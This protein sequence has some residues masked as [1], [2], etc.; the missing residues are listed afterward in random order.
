[1]NQDDPKQALRRDE[2]HLWLT[3]YDEIDDELQ[4]SYRRMVV[5]AAEIAQEQRF[6]F[7]NDRHRYLVTR[8]LV[9]TVL[10]RYASIAP[11]EWVFS[12]NKYGRPEVDNPEARSAGIVFNVS[13][14]RGL[15]ALG[16]TKSCALGLDVENV[17]STPVLLDLADRYF[18]PEELSALAALPR[19][20]QQDR[21]FEY[22][23]FKESYIKARGMGL[24]IPLDKFSFRY[25]HAHGV[26]IVIRPEMADNAERWRFWQLR[27]TNPY[28]IAVC[29]ERGDLQAP[30]LTVR[31]V[32]PL[33]S[34]ELV[35]AELLRATA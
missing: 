35:A 34:E 26:E 12:T 19:H 29:A 25:P 16:V 13:H 14:T 5:S 18:A 1:M 27:P 15:I 8:A 7:A 22:W 21:F 24:S 31:K 2:I 3:F 32:V 9:R 33:A 4:S 17:H 20:L 23:T 28:L 30:Q 10:A 6:Y 11:E